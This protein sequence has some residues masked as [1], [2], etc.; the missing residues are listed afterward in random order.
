[1]PSTLTP[2]PGDDPHDVVVVAPDAVR[3][4]PS[5]DEL[6]TLLHQA[7]RRRSDAPA[8]AAP[9]T[10]AGPVAPPVDT[11]FRPAA[12][13]DIPVASHPR[14]TGRGTLRGFTALLLAGC[15][16][17]T[18][19]AWRSWGETAEK[20]IAKWTTQFVLTAS[21]PAEEAA[22][23]AQPVVPEVRAD[24]ASTESAQP[25][26]VAGTA[27]EGPASTAALPSPDPEPLLQS[28][29]RDVASLGQQVEQ[30]KASI[31]Q[32]KAGQAQLSRDVAKA[33]EIKASETKVSEAKASETKASDQPRRARKP[34]SRPRAAAPAH[35]PMPPRQAAAAPSLPQSIAPY[36]PPQPA[37]PPQPVFQRQTDPE[38]ASVPRPPMPLR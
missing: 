36:V 13:D 28:M 34:A 31:E 6:S 37:P 38:L 22:P 2:K 25:A 15:I 33:S 11:T 32:I 12:V 8:D 35:K 19:F 1:M 5:D 10:S 3:V 20:K 14:P 7:A 26:S 4:A 24:A 9:D 18:A 27:A 23:A 29:A 30:L 17:V 16:G 21:Q